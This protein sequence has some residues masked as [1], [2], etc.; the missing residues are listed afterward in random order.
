VRTLIEN[1]RIAVQAIGSK[2]GRSFLTVLGVL[3][4]VFAITQLLAIGQGVKAEVTKQIEGLGTQVVILFPGKVSSSSGFNPASTFG[5][6]TLKESD[7]AVI[8]SLPTVAA[9]APVMI[10]SGQ[11]S[12]G[13]IVDNTALIYGTTASIQSV[14]PRELE[15]GRYF[16]DADV[17]TGASVTVLGA[18]NRKLLFADSD[19]IGQT[20]RA[21]SH[22]FTVVG[23][24]RE[25]DSALQFGGANADGI[26][27]IP[28]TTGQA[29]TKQT[30]IIRI[31]VKFTEGTDVS[32]AVESLTAAVRA[33]HNGTDDFSVL[34]QKDLL[35]LIGTILNLLTLLVSAIASVSLLVGGIGI[36]NIMLVSVTERTREIGLRKAI[37]ASDRDILVQFLTEAVLLSALGSGLG[38]VL[39][40]V[41]SRVVAAQAGFTPVV[42]LNLVLLAAGFALA[43]GVIFGLAPALRAARLNPIDALRYE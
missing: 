18:E 19:P 42:G 12:R 3:I 2:K 22:D 11:V 35:K 23:V 40:V 1:L 24:L 30:N 26:M 5:V 9:V 14:Y 4:G 6:S 39:A 7:V 36:M 32:A 33:N 21:Q 37:G 25:S 43:V 29:I 31:L 27:Y 41:S 34:T 17:E 10:I 38:L 16:T 8:D 20:V 13:E 15:S 28:L